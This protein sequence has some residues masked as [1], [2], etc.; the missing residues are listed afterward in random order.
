MKN[1]SVKKT[2]IVSLVILLLTTIFT[3]PMS[4]SAMY[5]DPLQ[6]ATIEDENENEIN[7]APILV[8]NEQENVAESFSTYNNDTKCG[9][10]CGFIA[11]LVV[12]EGVKYLLKKPTNQVLVRTIVRSTVSKS[13]DIIRNY[14][15]YSIQSGNRTITITKTVMKHILDRHHPDYFHDL[16]DLA[17]PQSFFMDTISTTIINNIANQAVRQNANKLFTN[18]GPQ[19][20]KQVDHVYNGITYRVGVD[21]VK[22]RVTQV[23]PRQT[24]TRE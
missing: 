6:S 9:P 24:F 3:V 21:T 12:R 13:D 18:T 7:V 19:I 17:E 15:P 5:S 14:T 22:N 23:Y 4:T 10:P 11:V 16:G 20:F 2:I 1:I 8:S